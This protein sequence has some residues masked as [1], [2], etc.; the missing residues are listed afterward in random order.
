MNL[1]ALIAEAALIQIVLNVQ[2]QHFYI[3]IA[4]VYQIAKIPILITTIIHRIILVNSVHNPVLHVKEAL[5]QT[6]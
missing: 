2:Q 5:I 6:V 1:L 3:I 4:N